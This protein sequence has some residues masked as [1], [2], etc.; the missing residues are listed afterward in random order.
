MNAGAQLCDPLNEEHLAETYLFTG[1]RIDPETGLYYYRTRY[2]DPIAGRFTVRDRIGIW[3]DPLE[4]GNGY[5]YVGNDPWVML[6]PLGF[7]ATDD[8][9]F[10][11][12]E[13]YRWRKIQ[14]LDK[15]QAAGEQ[16]KIYSAPAAAAMLLLIEVNIPDPSDLITVSVIKATAKVATKLG[17]KAGTKITV[18]A[19]KATGKPI[20]ARVGDL[21]DDATDAAKAAKAAETTVEQGTKRAKKKSLPNSI[22]ER[23]D[24]QGRVRS[25]TFYDEN[26]HPFS[27]QDFDHTHNR[28][29]PHEH[30]R[31]FDDQGRP[32]TPEETT[33]LS[34]G[35]DDSPTTSNGY[36][37]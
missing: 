20:A 31:R 19:D 35:Y 14:G 23:V 33:P 27:R 18:W 21:A 37:A 24:D 28:I 11:A 7:G 6:D 16:V 10:A 4:L 5:S 22:Y 29:R 2:V 9:A 25:R 13:G 15:V 36:P 34:S 30:N 17:I 1:R 32:I 26:G 12:A 3:T 8:D